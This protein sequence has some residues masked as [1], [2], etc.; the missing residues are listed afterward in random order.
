MVTKPK[1]ELQENSSENLEAKAKETVKGIHFRYS[2]GHL[3]ISKVQLPLLESPGIKA[4]ENSRLQE[5]EE[6]PDVDFDFHERDPCL[7]GTPYQTIEEANLAYKLRT[8]SRDMQ[9]YN[10]T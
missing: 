2:Y 3:G 10:K 8:V 6:E 1:R 4:S 5:Y 9:H 7:E